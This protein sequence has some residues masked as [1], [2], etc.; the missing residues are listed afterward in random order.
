MHRIL[1]TGWLSICAFGTLGICTFGKTPAAVDDAILDEQLFPKS[2]AVVAVEPKIVAT[3][4]DIVPPCFARQVKGTKLEVFTTRGWGWVDRQHV[5]TAAETEKYCATRTSEPYALYLRSNLHLY[6]D[7]PDQALADLNSAIK[8]DPKFAPAL[9][10]RG[11][12]YAANHDYNKALADF[13][14][15]VKLA[16]QDLLAAND[17]A[18][19]RATCADARFR[20]GKLAVA[21]ATRACAGAAYTNEEFLDTLAAAHAE[22]GDFKSALKWASRAAEIDPENEDFAKHVKLFKAGKPLRDDAQ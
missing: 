22:A 2:N 9:C 1:L 21:D 3:A 14:A 11:N 17:I 4:A 6:S 18:W 8:L 13:T 10:A 15:A 5:M 7:K 19:F 12:M 16:P 20:D